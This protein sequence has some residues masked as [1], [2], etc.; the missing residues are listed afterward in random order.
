MSDAREHHHHGDGDNEFGS[1]VHRG[2]YPLIPM[3]AI[4][5]GLSAAHELGLAFMLGA[6][7]AWLLCF[8]FAFCASEHDWKV[9]SL[10][11]GPPRREATPAA[12]ARLARQRHSR[13]LSEVVFFMLAVVIMHAVLPK[14]YLGPWWAK[15]AA[16][17]VY[18]LTAAGLAVMS[19]RMGH[20]E[21]YRA[22]C[23]IEWC[24]AGLE[25]KPRTE[26]R[27]MR[28]MRHGHYGVWAVAVLAPGA[29]AVGLFTTT[30][31]YL[32]LRIAYGLLLIF[33]AVAVA[34]ITIGH[35]NM[36]CLY[37]AKSLPDNPEQEAESRM[38]WLLLFH[39]TRY[40][41]LTGAG[42]GWV[43][44][45]VLAGT[46]PAKVLVC[47]AALAVLYWA[48]LERVHSPVK[49]W[50]PWCKDDGGEDAGSEAPDPA[51]SVPSPA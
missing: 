36:P 28:V 34:D 6:V 29:C 16:G 48:V 14:P 9:C 42:I 18:F 5:S 19:V 10:C 37:C 24:R 7:A 20:H 4:A 31:P 27:Q 35:S 26:R 11:D 1:V 21:R 45:W 46:I 2:R 15:A 49:P 13:V 43:V 47:T 22:E 17:V 32:L 33:L 39:R 25:R 12:R 41:V 40:P 30:H 3:L 44:S 8:F 23:H 50:C 51:S 38:S